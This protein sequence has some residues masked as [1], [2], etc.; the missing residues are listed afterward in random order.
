[1]T[2]ITPIRE[3]STR[4]NADYKLLK[5]AEKFEAAELPDVSSGNIQYQ[6]YDL[7]SSES[8]YTKFCQHVSAPMGLSR[9]IA[10]FSGLRIASHGQGAYKITWE[11][12][13]KHKKSGL[14]ITFYDWKGGLSMGSNLG[15]GKL[16]ASAKKDILELLNVLINERCPHPYDGCKVGEE[17]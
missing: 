1:M 15:M 5:I 4:R 7:N 16:K 8:F 12:A 6:I 2:N 3:V 10:L 14:V 13:L 17:A 9:L 11:V